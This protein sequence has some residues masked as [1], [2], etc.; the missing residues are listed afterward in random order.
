MACFFSP[1]CTFSDLWPNKFSSTVI[2]HQGIQNKGMKQS[3]TE[4]NYPFLGIINPIGIIAVFIRNPSYI[5]SLNFSQIF[6]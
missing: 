1:F 3:L 2:S 4:N 6:R 5:L